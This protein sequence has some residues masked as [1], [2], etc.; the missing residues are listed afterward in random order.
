MVFWKHVMLHVVW[1]GIQL[2]EVQQIPSLLQALNIPLLTQLAKGTSI[3]WV[4][5]CS[6]HKE[7]RFI[8]VISVQW[9]YTVTY[10]YIYIYTSSFQAL[11]L[12][13][14]ESEP[15]LDRQISKDSFSFHWHTILTAFL[16]LLQFLVELEHRI[17]FE[18]REGLVESRYWSAVTSHTAYWSSL[19]IALFLLTFMYKHDQDDTDKSNL[20]A[21]WSFDWGLGGMGK[22]IWKPMAQNGCQ[23][24]VCMAWRFQV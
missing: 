18:L 2:P 24:T 14:A 6:Y 19:D 10:I 4:F 20:D 22:E 15:K 5:P 17:D 1:M 23:T 3:S 11:G 13:S 16:F 8:S 12:V 21:I 9:L 7:H